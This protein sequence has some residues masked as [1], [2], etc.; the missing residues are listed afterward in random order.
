M[1]NVINT[2]KKIFHYVS[3]FIF[4]NFFI[5]TSFY[6]LFRWILNKNFGFSFL[7]GFQEIKISIFYNFSTKNFLV[8]FLYI[9]YIF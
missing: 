8:D 7:F 4:E 9:F 2:A 3:F 1:F 6:K 5:L